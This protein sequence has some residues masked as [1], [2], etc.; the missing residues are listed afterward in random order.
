MAKGVFLN[1]H[2]P[3]LGRLVSIGCRPS[4]G[5]PPIKSRCGGKVAPQFVLAGNLK[6]LA[7]GLHP[8]LESSFAACSL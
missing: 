4:Q 7:I 1:V 5:Q 8:F 6:N 3:L 2:E